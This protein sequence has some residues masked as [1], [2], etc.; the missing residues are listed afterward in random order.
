[1][2]KNETFAECLARLRKIKGISKKSLSSV[3]GLD[4]SYLSGLESGRRPV[5]RNQQI[6]KI[7]NALCLSEAETE[8]LMEAK[9][10]SKLHKLL[11]EKMSF[12]K[13]IRRK[14]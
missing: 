3:S 1:M 12:S 6:Y 13:E 14:S 9:I 2:D 4:P 11:L 10:V 8:Q 7:A 5:P